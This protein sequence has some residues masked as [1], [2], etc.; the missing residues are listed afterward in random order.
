MYCINMKA[1]LQVFHLYFEYFIVSCFRVKRLDNL[2]VP[3][4]VCFTNKIWCSNMTLKL[5]VHQSR[6]LLFFCLIC[7]EN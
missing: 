1:T 7:A 2:H 5:I 4:R 6:L 3:F